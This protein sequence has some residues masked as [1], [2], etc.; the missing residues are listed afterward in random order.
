MEVIPTLGLH[1][2]MFGK[3]VGITVLPLQEYQIKTT[4]SLLVCP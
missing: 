4:S 2:I 1:K 3:Y